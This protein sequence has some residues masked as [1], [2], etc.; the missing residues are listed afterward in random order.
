MAFALP[1]MDVTSE[2]RDVIC[3]D[4]E[5]GEWHRRSAAQRPCRSDLSTARRHTSRHHRPDDQR[6]I[7]ARHLWRRA[8]VHHRAPPLGRAARGRSDALRPAQ[9]HGHAASLCQLR[10]RQ[11]LSVG[12][13]DGR[14]RHELAVQPL[15]RRRLRQR[16]SG[17]KERHAQPHDAVQPLGLVAAA[18]ARPR[19]TRAAAALQCL[20]AAERTP[21]LDA[22]RQHAA[23]RERR[24]R[25]G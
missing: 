10:Q 11:R 13:A 24:V 3:S 12:A 25:R 5:F 2:L 22:A 1:G 8:S 15:W 4:F 7:P 9:H 19:R 21:G 6:H 16:G 23:E 18:H 20:G 17:S 14:W